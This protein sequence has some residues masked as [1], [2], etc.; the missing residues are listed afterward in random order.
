MARICCRQN[1]VIVLCNVRSEM[2]PGVGL[3]SDP[4]EF[5]YGLELCPGSIPECFLSDTVFPVVSNSRLENAC[6]TIAHCERYCDRTC[7]S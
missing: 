2:S 4:S 3:Q 6:F 5:L 7:I 1:Y